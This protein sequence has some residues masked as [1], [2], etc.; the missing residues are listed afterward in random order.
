MVN[1]ISF[2]LIAGINLFL[3]ATVVNGLF[4][5]PLWVAL[6]LLAV[7]I[8]PSHIISG[9]LAAVIYNEVLQFS[10][11]SPR[12]CRSPSSGCTASAVFNGLIDRVRTAVADGAEQLDSWP[13]TEL[14]GLSSSVL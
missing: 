1:A 3:L 4:G 11:K 10:S 5:W 8:V 7:A 9:G 2:A 12:C 14:T 13:C 6:L